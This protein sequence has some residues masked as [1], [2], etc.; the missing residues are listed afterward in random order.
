MPP[1]RWILAVTFVALASTGPAQAQLEWTRSQNNPTIPNGVGGGY[2]LAPNVLYDESAHVWRMWFTAKDYG[3]PWSLFSATSSDGEAWSMSANNP[4]IEGSSADFESDGAVYAGVVEEHKGYTIFYTGVHGCCGSAVG[5]AT[6]T[7]GLHWTK[8]AGNPVLVPSATGFDAV[9]IGTSLAVTFDGKTYRL[10]YEGRNGTLSQ[11]GLA[12]STDRIHWTKDPANPVLAAGPPGSWDDRGAVATSIFEHGG[13]LYMIYTG[14][15]SNSPPQGLGLATSADGVTWT[16]FHGNPIFTS[17]GS[18]RWDWDVGHACAV[19]R[20]DLLHLWYSGNVQDGVQWS[21]GS[22]TSRFAPRRAVADRRPNVDQDPPPGA[23]L[24]LPSFPNP[25]HT[26]A[27]IAY[28][29]PEHALVTLRVHDLQGREVASLVHEDKE[30]GRY[31][32]VWDAARARSG[33]YV[34]T[35]SAGGHQEQR[36]LVLMK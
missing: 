25:F 30:P 22:A 5:F 18:G 34:C 33:V 7:D 1:R 2:A 10:Y 9:L 12:T 29:L 11:T 21:I 32:A 17:G 3:G 16:K 24:L 23:L 27:T 35:L 26:A 19:L 28:V 31:E 20:A 6:S 4:V 8:Y 36:R 13:T 15:S 14:T